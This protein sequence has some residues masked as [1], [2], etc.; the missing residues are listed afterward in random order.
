MVKD[1]F[2]V[3]QGRISRPRST[4]TFL[5]GVVKTIRTRVDDEDAREICR[6]LERQ[7]KASPEDADL[8]AKMAYE[9]FSRGE[10]KEARPYAD[11]ALE[12]K[13]HHPL[14]SYVKARL[15][16]SIGDNSAAL[17]V[18]ELALDWENPNE[19]VIDLLAELWM[20]SG[21]LDEAEKLYETARKDDPAQTKWIAGL[22][23]VHLRQDAQDK[24][25]NDLAMIAANDADDLSVRK[26]LADYHA[27]SGHKDEAEKWA[28]ECLYVNVYEPANHLTLGDALSANKKFAE[29]A[30]EYQVAIDL[31]VK[32]PNDVKVKLASALRSAGK[33]PEAK[34]AL[35][36]VLKAD[37][38]HPV[39]KALREEMDK[40]K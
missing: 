4:W 37:P 33:L 1:C 14:A 8:N 10:K 25:L 32:K 3:V 30:E 2:N 39:A 20:K 28:W 6:Q 7:V 13:A 16:Q 36:S 15:L 27:K 31:K 23:R 12:L 40:G 29:A 35:D 34:A 26:T 24:L 17:D 18:L 22:A 21:R 11:K 19:R 9:H 38:E 5:D